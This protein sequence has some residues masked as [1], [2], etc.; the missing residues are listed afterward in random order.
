MVKQGD[1]VIVDFD[2]SLGSEQIGKCPGVIVSNNVYHEKTNGFVIIVPI[3]S[4]KA[5]QYPLHVSLDERTKT[6]GQIM[7]EQLKTMDTK[8]RQLKTIE[9]LPNDLL[10]KTLKIIHL[11]F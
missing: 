7:C 1:I 5:Y 6:Y 8:V 10:D 2:P 3:T 4:D 11:L 9:R